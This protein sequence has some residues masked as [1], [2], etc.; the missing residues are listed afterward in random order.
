M[1]LNTAPERIDVFGTEVAL[2]KRGAGRPLLY[3]HSGD[4]VDADDVFVGL[5]AEHFTVYAPSHPGF[6]DSPLPRDF[7]DVGDLAYL[8]LELIR[9]FELRDCILAGSSFGGWIAAEMAIRSAEGIGGLVLAAPMGLDLR[10]EDAPPIADLLSVALADLPGLLF[11]DADAGHAAFGHFRFK[12]MPEEAVN[13][14]VR[15]REAL[16]LYGWSPTFCN[17]AL[18]RWVARICVPTLVLWGAKDRVVTPVYA[19]FLTR[20]IK[21]ARKH[22]VNDAGHYL[23]IEN[24]HAFSKAIVDFAGRIPHR[25]PEAA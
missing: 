2:I 9:Q 16:T 4:G 21:G 5:L 13:R 22:V 15:N 1:F 24:P 23:H 8:Y 17:P 3:L 10:S 11:A 6:G 12:D 19:D 25:T 20:S 18:R 7:Q 14:F